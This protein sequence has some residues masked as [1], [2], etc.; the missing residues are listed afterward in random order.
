MSIVEDTEQ[1]A[2]DLELA[3]A[4]DLET[5]CWNNTWI[6]L[7]DAI[8]I[9][10]VYTYGANILMINPFMLNFNQ[11]ETVYQVTQFDNDYQWLVAQ[12]SADNASNPELWSKFEW[13]MDNAGD[14]YLC[15]SETDA[16]TE[17][18]AIDAVGADSTDMLTG[19]NGT[20]WMLITLQ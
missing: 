19:C 5:G 14:H 17:Q 1:D 12:N 20:A 10:G 4:T 11:S 8:D 3:D 6:E 2:L 15:Q 9:N 7:K 13:A 16:A 18:D